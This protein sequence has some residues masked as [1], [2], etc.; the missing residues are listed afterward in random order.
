[1]NTL[2]VVSRPSALEKTTTERVALVL[3]VGIAEKWIVAAGLATGAS[4]GAP[5]SGWGV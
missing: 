2:R 5:L 4:A 1:M 3:M